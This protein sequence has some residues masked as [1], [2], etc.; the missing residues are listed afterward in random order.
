MRSIFESAA[1]QCRFWTAAE[2]S[3]RVPAC[4]PRMVVTNIKWHTSGARR[5]GGNP[6]SRR[7]PV[8]ALPGYD[9]AGRRLQLPGPRPALRSYLH[10]NHLQDEPAWAGIPGQSRGTRDPRSRSCSG[11]ALLKQI[12]LASGIENLVANLKLDSCLGPLKPEDTR[13][14]YLVAYPSPRHG[15]VRPWRTKPAGAMPETHARCVRH[16]RQPP[17]VD[18]AERTS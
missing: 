8:F 9:A 14:P 13:R 10:D 5:L 4:V 1:P 6:D 17:R 16:C 2:P 12:P 7:G 3:M 18:K 11:G 15:A